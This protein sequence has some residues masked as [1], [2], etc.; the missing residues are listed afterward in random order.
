MAISL[1]EQHLFLEAIFLR[2]GFDFRQYA[3]ASLSRRIESI[4]NKYPVDGVYGLIEKTVIDREFF[5]EILPLF[6][7]ST[8]EFF[9]D[10]SFFKSVRDKAIPV[11]KTYPH[12]NIWIAGCSTGE[13]AYSMAILLQEEGLYEKT[14]IHATDINPASLRKAKDGIF[15]LDSI[16]GLIKN[17]TEFGGKQS[18]SDYYTA[19]YGLARINSD[20]IENIVF[21]EHNLVTDAAFTEAHVILCRNVM[22]Y[23]NR[24][25]QNQVL[26]LFS[27]SLTLRGFLGLGSKESLKFHPMGSHFESLDDSWK[28][29]R[30]KILPNTIASLKPERGTP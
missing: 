27:D 29:F 28:L 21:S 4:L 13:E 11:L 26:K 8:S 23:F 24:N 10:P 20:F 1:I 9:R 16:K 17:Y 12:I 15:P 22:I 2:Y 5:Y 14:T 18:P 19:D 25:L 30:K 7:V 3:A 6:T